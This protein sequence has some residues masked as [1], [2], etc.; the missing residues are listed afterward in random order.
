MEE[1]SLPQKDWGIFG[2]LVDEFEIQYLNPLHI[3]YPP[4]P[5]GNRFLSL[6]ET[7]WG[8]KIIATRGFS[9]FSL[10]SIH[11]FYLET[12]DHIAD[13]G[14]SWCANVIY[15]VGAVIPKVSDF[16]QR[17]EKF[18]YLS[19][20][21]F[22]NDAPLEWTL[23]S[24]NGNIGLFLGL[25]HQHLKITKTSFIPVNVKL[26]RPKELQYILDNGQSGRQK[27]ANLFAQT[28]LPGLSSITRQ[29]LM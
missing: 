9:N 18:N 5:G 2:K 15:E 19:F 14:S 4:W 20:Q 11:E 24:P 8:T 17:L 13:F 28:Q 1:I 7:N 3:H 6:Y 27:L 26:L 10:S 21:C 12:T 25:P 29:S 22:I 16:K 23:D